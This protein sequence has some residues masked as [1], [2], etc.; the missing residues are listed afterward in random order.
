MAEQTAPLVEAVT[1]LALPDTVVIR[2]MPVRR[3]RAAHR[4]RG[5]RLLRAEARELRPPRGSRRAAKVTHAADRTNLR[6][7]WPLIGAQTVAF[8]PQRPELVILPQALREAGFLDDERVL[9]KVVGHEMTHLAQHAADDGEMWKRQDT[10]YPGLR[11][12]ADRDYAFL[13]EGHAYWAD[14]QITTKLLGEPVSTGEISP[15]ATLRYR[16]LAEPLRRAGDL[17]SFTAAADAVGEIVAAQGLEA[18]NRV[19]RCPELVPTRDEAKEPA[20]WTHR[21]AQRSLA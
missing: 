12:T 5:A 10:F 2:T 14:R 16:D 18:F 7:I 9:C 19:W 3:W 6:R 20:R 11:G 8:R 17:T 13:V 21:F 1:G 15:H 4:R